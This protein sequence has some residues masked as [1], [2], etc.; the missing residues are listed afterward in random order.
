L[1]LGAL[2][3]RAQSKVGCFSGNAPLRRCPGSPEDELIE[4]ISRYM[5]FSI[6]ALLANFAKDKTLTLKTLEKKFHCDSEASQQDL[7]I[8][9][10]CPGKIGVLIKER[11]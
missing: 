6:A 8:V 2:K 7:Q 9:H 4:G 1:P 3:I 5:E 10:R 11:G